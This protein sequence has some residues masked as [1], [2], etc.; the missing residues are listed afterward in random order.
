MSSDELAWSC[1]DASNTTTSTLITGG[2]GFIG[3]HLAERLLAAGHH[4]I[5]IDDLSTGSVSNVARLS[6]YPGF[7]FVRGSVLDEKLVDGLMSRVDTAFHLAAA[8]GVQLILQESLLGLRTNI[9]GTENVL[10]CAHRHGVRTLI[11]STSEV[12]GKNP[13]APL[14]EDDDRLIGS[15]LI[16][17]WS[18]SEAKALDETMAYLY[19][20]DLGTPVVIARLFNVAG[21]KQTGR[22]G[23][24]IPRF[25]D[26][27]LRG[28]RLTVYGDGKQTRSFCHVWDAV[29]GL[30]ALLE[31]PATYGKAVNIGRPEEVSIR[32]LAERVI[33]VTGS[34]STIEHVPYADA[35]GDGFED[36]MRRVP[37]IALARELVGFDPHLGLDDIIMSVAAEHGSAATNGST[38]SLGSEPGGAEVAARVR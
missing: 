38:M 23:M 7:E 6:D 26:Q 3:G 19:W 25:V 35:Y 16:R 21:P 2:A 9:Q 12:Y 8:V 37:D 22:Y 33:A 36:T 31:H 11:A 18:Y 14:R 15:P 17:R 27:A 1:N 5:C 4:V 24:V 20:S 32:Q 34:V 28:E 13:A 30:I 10:D 29:D